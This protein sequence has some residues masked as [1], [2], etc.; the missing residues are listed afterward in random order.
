MQ[1]TTEI[2]AKFPV[3][4]SF[5]NENKPTPIVIK[6]YRLSQ[7]GTVRRFVHPSCDGDAKIIRQL[8]GHAS[9]NSVDMEL[10]RDLSRGHIQFEETIAP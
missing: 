2:K 4:Q 9:I 1:T 7:Y 6:W 3:G 10:I 5:I 8:I